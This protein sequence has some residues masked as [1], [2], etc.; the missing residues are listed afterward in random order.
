MDT[1]VDSPNPQDSGGLALLGVDRVLVAEGNV[2]RLRWLDGTSGEPAGE[3]CL[4][5]LFPDHCGD[6][7]CALW[8]VSHGVAD[9]EDRLLVAYERPTVAGDPPVGGV[10]LL[11]PGQPTRV[12]AD[13]QQLDWAP[14]LAGIYD[15]A[16]DTGSQQ[17]SCRLTDPHAVAMTAAGLW[18]VGD[19]SSNRM[20]VLEPPEGGGTAGTATVLASLDATTLPAEVWEGCMGVNNVEVVQAD[21]GRELA[22]MTCKGKATGNGGKVD[23]GH[24][25]LW[26]I[27]DPADIS[28]L[29]RFP[30]G[31]A[32][33]W[34][35]HHGN[36]VAGPEGPL[37]V[38]GH[39][40]GAS[41]G[42][43]DG[44][45]LGSVGVAEFSIDVTPTYLGDGLLPGVEDPL[46]FVRG[47]TAL[48]E[49][50][51]LLVTDSGCEKDTARGCENPRRLVEVGWPA[52][53]P[54]GLG[55][56][57]SDDHSDQAFFSL[58]PLG[59]WTDVSQPYEAHRLAGADLGRPLGTAAVLGCD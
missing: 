5:A 43:R 13:V 35:V 53:S 38:W 47:V 59:T 17:A 21:D 51:G 26:D 54:P 49:G 39:S 57:H 34:A 4:T 41:T 33:L 28:R 1:A 30:E 40:L 2:G 7:D 56:G 52:L 42:P 25:V 48:P 8:S 46:G 9:G 15:G 19:S 16:C 3:I 18:V 36:V 45:E 44:Q 31:E 10:L 37:L 58:D 27:S 32:Y 20:L 24:L 50:G 22:L 12:L 23:H 6:G 29:W 11:A 55:G 14:Q